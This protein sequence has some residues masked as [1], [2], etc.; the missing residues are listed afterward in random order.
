MLSTSYFD[1]A[2]HFVQGKLTRALA[3]RELLE[4]ITQ[5][6]YRQ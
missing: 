4:K 5:V 6:G 1:I 3:L 2:Q